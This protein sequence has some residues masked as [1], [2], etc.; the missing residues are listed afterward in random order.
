MGANGNRILMAILTGVVLVWTLRF[1]IQDGHILFHPQK[2]GIDYPI[3]GTVDGDV[4]VQVAQV[5]DAICDLL[6]GADVAVGETI[7]KA[8]CTACHQFENEI[9]GQGPHLVALI[10]RAVASTDF[11]AYSAALKGFGGQWDQESLN[12]FLFKPSAYVPGTA[13]N[14]A[15]W[16]NSKNRQRAN[17]IAY[18]YS[19][20]GAA[21]PTCPLPDEAGVSEG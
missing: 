16:D 11:G 14:F 10:G 4:P 3:V 18:L 7:A 12:Y 6:A 19:L 1:F 17:V 21:L 15:G 5:P 20:S 13:M 9:H 2:P 8:N